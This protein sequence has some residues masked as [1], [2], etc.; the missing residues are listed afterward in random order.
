MGKTIIVS[1]VHMSDENQQYAWFTKECIAPFYHFLSTILGDTSNSEVVLLGDIFDT[2]LYPVDIVPL[3]YGE[4][5]RKYSSITDLFKNS[6][7]KKTY[8][9]CGNHDITI[10]QKDLEILGIELISYEDFNKSHSSWHLEHGN[11]VDL[12]N[13]PDISGS[14]LAGLPLGYYITRLAASASEKSNRNIKNDLYEWLIENMQKV[15]FDDDSIIISGIIDFLA[16]RAGID[17]DT[18]LIRFSDSSIDNKYYVK[19]IKQ[20][21]SK[22]IPNWYKLD[23]HN[24]LNSALAGILN[25]GLD[26]YANLMQQKR[27]NSSYQYI[28]FGHTHYGKVSNKYINDGCWCCSPNNFNPTYI[29][30]DEQGKAVL[31]KWS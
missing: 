14:P 27:E 31:K 19:D 7:N 8:Y 9:I 4:I 1:D 30:I 12:F 22:L 5:I 24:I 23:P 29:E 21:Y 6:Q 10:T 15:N 28:I 16:L 25:D 3:T 17:P 18:T 13:A 26:W 11:A 20:H 2:W